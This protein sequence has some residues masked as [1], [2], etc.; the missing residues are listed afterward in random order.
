MMNQWFRHPQ[1]LFIVDGIGA[2]VSAILHIFL[3]APFESFFGV[4]AETVYLLALFP[5]VFVLYDIFAY[6]Q[7]NGLAQL[8]LKGIAVMN[9]MFVALSISMGIYHRDSISVWGWLYL[10]GECLIVAGLVRLEWRCAN[11]KT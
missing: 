7:Y 6:Y 2:A 11:E 8:Y 4:P 1:K 5:I 10:I 3:L 9:M